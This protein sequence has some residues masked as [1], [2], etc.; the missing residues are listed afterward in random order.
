MPSCT[1]AEH[2]GTVTHCPHFIKWQS[3]AS[4]NYA[5]GLEPATTVPDGG[6]AYKQLAPAAKV[7]FG[8]S[9]KVN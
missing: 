4:G 9:R 2:F 3:M 1:F 6:F 8:I 7:R 5:L